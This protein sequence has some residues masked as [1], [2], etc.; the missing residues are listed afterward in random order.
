LARPGSRS[1]PALHE[2]TWRHSSFD[3]D[4]RQGEL[5]RRGP[6]HGALG[7]RED[8]VVGDLQTSFSHG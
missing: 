8:L 2:S 6:G 1:K 5:V 4:V 3:A 7:H